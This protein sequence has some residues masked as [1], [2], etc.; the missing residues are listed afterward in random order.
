MESGRASLPKVPFDDARPAKRISISSYRAVS[1]GIY[2]TG[3][4]CE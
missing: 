4:E 1:G 2:A 3:I